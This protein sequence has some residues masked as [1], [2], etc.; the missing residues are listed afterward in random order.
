MG[1]WGIGIFSDDLACDVRDAFKKVLQ[2]ELSGAQA[3][4][5]VLDEFADCLKDPDDGPLLYLALAATQWNYGYPDQKIINKAI[6]IIDDGEG[7]NRWKEVNTSLLEKRESVLHK[8]K[9][10]L[11]SPAPSPK[12]VKSYPRNPF[13]VGDVIQIKLP[14]GKFS[15]VH[16]FKEEGVDTKSGVPTLFLV[17]Y[18]YLSSNEPDPNFFNYQLLLRT[19]KNP[20]SVKDYNEASTPIVYGVVGGRPPKGIYKV[21]YNE[22]KYAKILES[23]KVTETYTGWKRLPESL[24]YV[25]VENTK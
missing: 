10:Q 6:K 11:L 12:K 5:Y 9:Q 23:Y 20:Y 22:V 19:F 8:L 2:E 18:D 15:L 7:L 24:E 25:L 13:K 1:T 4:K 16:I 21:L 14:N 3:T 17:M